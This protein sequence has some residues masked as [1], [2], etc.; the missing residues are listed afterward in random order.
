MPQLLSIVVAVY[1]DWAALDLCLRSLQEQTDGPKFEVVVVDDGS[2]ESAPEAIREWA[3]HFALTLVLQSHSGTS[4]ARNHGIRISKGSTLLFVDADSRVQRDCLAE[5]ESVVDHSPQHNYFQLRLTGVGTSLVG[6]AED[7]RLTTLQHRM[8]RA[9]GCIRYLNTAGFAIRKSAA[10]VE[11]GLFNPDARRAE[12]TL[13][14][15]SLIERDELPFFVVGAVIQHVVKL[16]LLELFRKSIRSA[17]LEG[18]MH[19]VIALR[20]RCA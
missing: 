9:D 10:E 3:R 7:L 8:H 14:L 4:A 20:G 12:D 15:A 6:R 5:L 11:T 2:S 18:A 19:D 13:L 17:V 16:S 1:N